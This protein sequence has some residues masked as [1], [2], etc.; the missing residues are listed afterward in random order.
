MSRLRLRGRRPTLWAA[1]LLLLTFSSGAIPAGGALA[2]PLIGDETIVDLTSES[3]LIALGASLS[4]GG[5]ALGSVAIPITGGDVDVPLLTGT[6]EHQGSL[7]TLSSAFGSVDL[8]NLVIDLTA[9]ILRAD[10]AVGD[11]IAIF[12]VR[13]CLLTT[14]SDPCLDDDGSLLVN[15]FGLDWTDAAATLVN[16][17]VFGGAANLAGGDAFGVADLDLRFGSVPE[18]ATALLLAAGAALLVGGRRFR[19]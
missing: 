19:R 2:L 7:I 9:S 12:E 4:G 6:V 3:D 15:G 11:G 17:V 5:P 13:S 10:T 1:C 16:D 14:A 8:R 18:P